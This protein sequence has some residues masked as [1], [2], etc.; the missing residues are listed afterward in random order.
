M[1]YTFKTK[2]Y[3]HQRDALKFLLKHRGGGLQV[4][5]RWGKTKVVID[6]CGC[7][8]YMEGVRR[9]LVI[10]TA[11]G[12]GVWEDEVAAHC[13][14][15]WRVF[16]YMGTLWS[17][18]EEGML[19]RQE[20]HELQRNAEAVH[21]DFVVVNYENVY[22]RLMDGRTWLPTSNPALVKFKADVVAVDESHRIGN[23][24]T[25]ASKYVRDLGKVA[26]FRVLLTGSMFH[27]KP[28][29]V[30]GQAL[31]YDQ[32]ISLGSDFGAYKK[33]V[34]MMGGYGGY[35]IIRYKN[36]KWMV[37]QVR[38]WCFI[39]KYVP[40]RPPVENVLHFDLTGT[41]LKHYTDMDKHKV[42]EV[43]GQK[44]I[45][46]IILTKHLRLAQITGGWVRTPDG[47]YR[48]IGGNK[49][50]ICEDRLTEYFEQGIE[51]AVVACRFIPELRTV[52]E[53]G[54]RIG[55][56]IILLHGGV[57][58]GKERAHRIRAFTNHKDPCLFIS[59]IATGA[60]SIN[61]SAASTMMFYSMTEDF[62]KF[63]QFSKRIE[64]FEDTRTLQYD[65][66][67]A[68]GTVDETM[69]DAM[70]LKMDYA[71]YI[72]THPRRVEKL[73]AK[74]GHW[75]ADIEMAA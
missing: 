66:L 43:D 15:P 2:P 16:D 64:L 47:K 14:V 10:T 29:Y 45:S 37:N 23:P 22:A 7:M 17:Q 73:L 5:M 74:P 13:A 21:L 25:V 24:T 62:V 4:P 58:V 53:I 59:Q 6:F 69:L 72:T 71:T 32:G 56:K 18:S 19:F 54:K 41:N 11:S 51:K 70:R 61:L 39:Q 27:R 63:D 52:A 42:V 50:K 67:V 36:L 44:I 3:P 60:E 12:L 9:V 30:F 38:S 20:G 34:A 48:K 1:K 8:Y 75:G 65:F 33:R 49:A 57:P 55:F 26:K 46:E 40:P 31:F 28:F 68:R 35:E